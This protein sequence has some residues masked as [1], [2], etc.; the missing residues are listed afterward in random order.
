MIGSFRQK[1]CGPARRHLAVPRPDAARMSARGQPR[2]THIEHNASALTPIADM[3]AD[4]DFRRFGPAS[5]I[6]E[7]GRR[8]TGLYLPSAG[9]GSVG[10]RRASIIVARRHLQTVAL[11]LIVIDPELRL[12]RRQ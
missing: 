7:I 5:D 10:C 6:N 2:L 8:A 11:R 12:F 9:N 4:I 3:E 1:S